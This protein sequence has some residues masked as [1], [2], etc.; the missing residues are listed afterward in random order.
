[1]RSGGVDD[2]RDE[3]SSRSKRQ[4]RKGEELTVSSSETW[5]VSRKVA[6]R[7]LDERWKSL[8]R[9]GRFLE[10]ERISKK[11]KVRNGNG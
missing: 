4:E 6:E 5:S 3:D 2:L 11:C 8:K 9:L 1:M 10:R 7:A